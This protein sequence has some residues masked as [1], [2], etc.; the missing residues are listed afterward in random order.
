[1][2]KRR[3]LAELERD[4]AAMDAESARNRH[5]LVSLRAQETAESQHARANEGDATGPSPTAVRQAGSALGLGPSSAAQQGAD[6]VGAGSQR[7]RQAGGSATAHGAAMQHTEQEIAE[8]TKEIR[9][10]EDESKAAKERRGS[11]PWSAVISLGLTATRGEAA[12]TA[13]DHGAES[14]PAPGAEGAAAAAR[15]QPMPGSRPFTA[16]DR[17]RGNELM[18]P[19]TIRVHCCCVAEIASGVFQ[20]TQSEHR[21]K[22]WATGAFAVLRGAVNGHPEAAVALMMRAD[23]MGMPREAERERESNRGEAAT[24]AAE[25]SGL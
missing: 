23:E 14:V 9:K 22:H 8:M 21:G 20:N 16:A 17:A 2:E 11:H 4:R 12:E 5:E 10:L 15:S 18:V 6:P 24:L 13:T 25:G 19:C 1:M 3:K 7:P